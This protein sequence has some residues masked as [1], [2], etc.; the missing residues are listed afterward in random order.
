[1]ENIYDLIVS[2]ELT[3]ESVSGK[4]GT[5]VRKVQDKLE[6]HKKWDSSLK[7]RVYEVK[8]IPNKKYKEIT[9]ALHNLQDAE[10][11][12]EYKLIG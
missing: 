8:D 1:M 9:N 2:N 10:T 6:L 4:V 7:N 12:V 3:E 11:Y 5:L